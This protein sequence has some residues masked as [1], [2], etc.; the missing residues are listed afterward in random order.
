MC[1]LVL[2]SW[3]HE[4]V[5]RSELTKP[6]NV[7][8]NTASEI[9]LKTEVE[10]GFIDRWQNGARGKEGNHRRTQDLWTQ[11]QGKGIS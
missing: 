10:P 8:V 9:L 2:Q 3:V 4:H 5:P 6:Y 1:G 7:E 11:G